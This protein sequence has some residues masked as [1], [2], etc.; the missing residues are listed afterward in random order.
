MKVRTGAASDVGRVRERNEDSYLANDPLFAVADGLGGHQ[1][2]DVASKTAL[3][4]LETEARPGDGEDG[5]PERLREGVVRAN[6]AVFE[7]ASGDPALAGMGTTITAIAA[8]TGRFYLAH[9][10]D[11]RAYMLRDGDLQPLTEDHTLVRRMV[12]EGRLTAEEAQVHPQRSVLT[13]A[14]GIEDEIEVD[15]ATI[16][17]AAGDRLLLCSDGLTGMVDEDDIRKIL[18]TEREPQRASERL[19]AA[20]NDAG[21]QDN[22]TVVIV[23]VVEGDPVPEATPA[24]AARVPDPTD[25]APKRAETIAPKRRIRWLRW[26]VALMALMAVGFIGGKLYLNSQWYVG[27]DGARVAIFRGVPGEIAGVELSSVE[28]RTRIPAAPALRL[29]PWSE[30]DEGITA[31]SEAEA[32]EIVRQ[33]AAD[34]GPPA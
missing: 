14:L 10:G 27:V 30:L 13:R 16:E 34:L 32:R 29:Q 5:L 17:T 20:A 11:S 24:D 19:V 6:Q 22:I 3:E 9:V 8:G 15:Q 25:R 31:G 21:G 18:A 33:I 2:G 23:D 7:R 26:I 12:R 28:E 1:G 4:T